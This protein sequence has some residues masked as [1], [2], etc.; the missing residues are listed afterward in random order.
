MRGRKIFLTAALV[1]AVGAAGAA[2]AN[3]FHF[4]LSRSA[5]TADAT[6]PPPEEVRLWFT[7]APQ[8]NSVRI[9]ILNAA[10]EPLATTDPTVDPENTMAVSVK[11]R[12]PLS[13]GSYTVSWRGVGD[14]GHAVTGDFGF[15]VRA[16]E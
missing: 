2:A 11:P 14:D 3:V 9:R 13:A 12:A 6:V 10:G 15:S 16:E 4:A 7:Q 5:P 8:D 1:F